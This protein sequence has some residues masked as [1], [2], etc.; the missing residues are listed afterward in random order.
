MKNARKKGKTRTLTDTPEKRLIELA[1]QERQTKNKTKR[2]R[3]EKRSLKIQRR[4]RF[5]NFHQNKYQIEFKK[6]QM[7]IGDSDVENVSL[8]DSSEGSFVEETSEEE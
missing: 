7:S 8:A 2:E 1:E 6:R 3:Q 5:L 4:N